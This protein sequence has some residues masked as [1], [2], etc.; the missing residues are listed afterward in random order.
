QRSEREK[1]R[2]AARRRR[3]QRRSRAPRSRAG[4]AR[5]AAPPFG[6]ERRCLCRWSTCSWRCSEHL[7]RGKLD[8][9]LK[10]LVALVEP[11]VE[12]DRP[13]LQ[14]SAVEIALRQGGLLGIGHELVGG[15]VGWGVA[16]RARE[17]RLR[18][19]L[20]R[21]RDVLDGELLLRRAL[22]DGVDLAA[23]DMP[24]RE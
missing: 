9:A 11:E 5:A 1:A 15:L 20:R 4:A 3:V 17:G 13:A 24:R 18:L 12:I 2:S 19:G 10:N 7:L 14:R 6:P 16:D 22:H 21:K 23:R 8:E